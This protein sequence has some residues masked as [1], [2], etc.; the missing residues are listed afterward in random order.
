MHRLKSTVGP[1]END[2]KQPSKNKELKKIKIRM[3]F[4]TRIYNQIPVNININII[5]II[6]I[7]RHN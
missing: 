5:I 1:I 6:I 7:S 2:R 3:N 4:I